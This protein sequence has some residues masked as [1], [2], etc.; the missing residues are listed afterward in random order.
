MEGGALDFFQRA[1]KK[2]IRRASGNQPPLVIDSAAPKIA[3]DCCGYDVIMYG[4]LCM[5]CIFKGFNLF[6][7]GFRG[8]SGCRRGAK[9]CETRIQASIE[10]ALSLKTR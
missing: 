2:R 7:C 9:R 6:S 5:T 1:A 3:Y 4:I 8:P 10:V